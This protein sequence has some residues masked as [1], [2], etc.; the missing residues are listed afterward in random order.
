MKENQFLAALASLAACW[1]WS[2]NKFGY[3]VAKNR[4]CPG[5]TFDPVTA[6]CRNAR[7]GTFDS[8]AA[9]ADALNIDPKLRQNLV[10]AMYGDENRGYS[11]VLRGRIKSILGLK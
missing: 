6:V 7:R 3:I 2:T 4:S 9:A 8:T 5:R 1:A 10:S 11:Q